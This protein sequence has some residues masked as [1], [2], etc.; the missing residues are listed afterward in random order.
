MV[1]QELRVRIGDAIN[2]SRYTWRTAKSLSKELGSSIDVITDVL[3]A[4]DTFLRARRPNASGDSL[5]T[6]SE[7]Y[8]RDTSLLERVL[9][10]A[11]NTVFD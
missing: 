4:S 11:A 5:Y 1:D 2:K 6:T 7:K 8:K 9:G 3:N 10:A